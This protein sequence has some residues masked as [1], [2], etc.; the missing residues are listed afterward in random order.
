M[1]TK[2]RIKEYCK[3]VFG[4]EDSNRIERIERMA[5]FIAS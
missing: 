3:L 5:R 1:N 4:Y 2:Q